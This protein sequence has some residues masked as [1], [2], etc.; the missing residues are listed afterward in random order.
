MCNQA[1]AHAGR[2]GV[3][4]SSD[5]ARA[6]KAGELIREEIGQATYA[7]VCVFMSAGCV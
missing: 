3:V 6:A 5:L 7:S 4:V 2:V 1:Y